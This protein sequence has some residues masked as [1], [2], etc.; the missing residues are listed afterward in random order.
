MSFLFCFCFLV[1][2]FVFVLAM[3]QTK[4]SNNNDSLEGI[5]IPIIAKPFMVDDKADKKYP[6]DVL[7]K[8]PEKSFATPVDTSLLEDSTDNIAT[9][10]LSKSRVMSASTPSTQILDETIDGITNTTMQTSMETAT[11]ADTSA[12]NASTVKQ[13]LSRKRKSKTKVT[14]IR[15]KK[16]SPESNDHE[17][18][19]LHKALSEAAEV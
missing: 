9:P 11:E 1:V 19:L 4:H 16:T 15:E 17:F 10:G 6:S 18:I 7:Q 3:E 8:E 13:H 2:F 5:I 14:E 12:T